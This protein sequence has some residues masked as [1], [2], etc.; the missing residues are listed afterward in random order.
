MYVDLYSLIGSRTVYLMQGINGPHT[1]KK[2]HRGNDGVH[3]RQNPNLSLLFV[4]R[5]HLFI[6]RHTIT[7]SMS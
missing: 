2:S 6:Y 1:N 3:I 4:V 7:V 5:A